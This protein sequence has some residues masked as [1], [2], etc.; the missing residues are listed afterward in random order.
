MLYALSLD[1]Q[2]DHKV[3]MPS[4]LN[5]VAIFHTFQS[6]LL[7]ALERE[8]RKDDP[9]LQPMHQ[10]MAWY[11]QYLFA[12]LNDDVTATSAAAI[13]SGNLARG[14]DA[15]LDDDSGGADA[16]P[17]AVQGHQETVCP[18]LSVSFTFTWF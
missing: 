18:T 12:P 11:D 15:L 14:L 17:D 1:S 6:F 8:E 7:K 16:E 2:L 5:Y 4:G 3:G 10:T 9:S 13:G